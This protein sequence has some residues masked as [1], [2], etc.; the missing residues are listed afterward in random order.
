MGKLKHVDWLLKKS[1]AGAIRVGDFEA[2][3][4]EVRA[5]GG[6]AEQREHSDGAGGFQ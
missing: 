6:G 3:R 4:E 1:N 2:S 5:G